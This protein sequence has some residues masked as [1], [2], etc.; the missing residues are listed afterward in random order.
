MVGGYARAMS[1]PDY[2]F[3]R[4]DEEYGATMKA[5]SENWGGPV[6]LRERA[7]SLAEDERF[8]SWWSSYL[9]NSA[10]P[11]AIIALTRMNWSIDIRHVLPAISVP[12]LVIHARGD[13]ALPVE[14][15]RYLAQHIAGARY[16]ELDSIDHIPFVADTDEVAGAIEEFVTGSR[17]TFDPDR[18]LATILYTDIV[19][20]TR[21]LSEIGDRRWRDLLES[22]NG[23][24]RDAVERAR[25]QVIKSTGD[26]VLATF[27]GPARAVRCA[28]AIRDAVRSLG[29]EVRAGLH[30]GECEILAGDIGGIATHI[31]ARVAAIAEPGEVL[32]SSTVRDLVAGSGIGFEDRGEREFKGVLGAWRVYRVVSA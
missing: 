13:Q 4:T 6:A 2:R 25:G 22:H 18:V 23:L 15:G 29:I 28:C 9:R 8:S 12:T 10:S 17:H 32:A 14:N 11:A 30:T 3:G 16:L 24:V 31:G 27:D 5:L 20:S 1:A 19:Q 21:T 7:P 26:G